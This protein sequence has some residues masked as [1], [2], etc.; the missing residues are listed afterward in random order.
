VAV[1]SPPPTAA[2][3]HWPSAAAP[4]LSPC[5]SPQQKSTPLASFSIYLLLRIETDAGPAHWWIHAQSLRGN[6]A[7][8]TAAACRGVRARQCTDAST[9]E[10]EEHG[11]EA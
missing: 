5:A 1:L 9:P 2:R 6:P 7:P 4:S 10:I 11:L 3:A 8:R